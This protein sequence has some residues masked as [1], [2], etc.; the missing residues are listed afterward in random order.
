MKFFFPD[1][2]ISA[3][4]QSALELVV[5]VD[6]AA[7]RVE[8]DRSTIPH[9]TGADFLDEEAVRDFISRNRRGI[10]LAIEAHLFA[11]G[12]PLDRHIVISREDLYALP[13]A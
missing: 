11:R 4:P 6:G 3:K 10:E 9:S 8:L 1:A 13:A 12:I 7:V 2:Q 5:V